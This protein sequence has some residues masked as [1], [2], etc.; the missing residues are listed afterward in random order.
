MKKLVTLFTFLA[1]S[2]TG[3]AQ[4][5]WR[6][7]VNYIIDVHLDDSTNS[8]DGFIKI[9]YNNQSPDTLH[10]IWFHL[11]PNAYKNDRTAYSEQSLQYRSTRFYFSGESE[12]GY[13]NQLDFRVDDIRADIED[14]PEHQDIIKLVLPQPLAPGSGVRISTPFHVK[15]PYNFSGEG[16]KE[17][18]FQLVQWYPKPA[19]YDQQGWHPMP[20][21]LR[22]GH[23]SESGNYDVTISVPENYVVAASGELLNETERE[24]LISRRDYY[25]E[26]IKKRV[27]IGKGKYKTIVQKYPES[28]KTIKRLRFRQQAVQ[29]FAWAADKRWS[30]LQDELTLPEQRKITLLAYVLP[31]AKERSKKMLQQVKETLIYY[32]SA[33]VP[34]PYTTVHVLRAQQNTAF[35]NMVWVGSPFIS[36]PSQTAVHKAVSYIWT[37]SVPAFNTW[38]HPWL[39]EGLSSLYSQKLDE[40]NKVR[41][42][43]ALF[44]GLQR[45]A[46][47]AVVTVKRDQPVNLA[48][49]RYTK[50][51]YWLSTNIKACSWLQLVEDSLGAVAFS[52]AIRQFYGLSGQQHLYPEDLKQQFRAQGL[53]DADHW[54]QQ[55]NHTGFLSSMPKRQLKFVR[56]D[57]MIAD[58]GYRNIGLAPALGYNYYDG[59]MLGGM[60]HNYSVPFGAFQFIAIPLYGFG[61]RQF[62]GIF[63]TSYSWYPEN[64]LYK[65]E[66]GMSGARFTGDYFDDAENSKLVRLP[67]AKLAPYIRAGFDNKGNPD[68]NRYLQLKYYHI[69]ED[70][71]HFHSNQ[72]LISN[73]P[74][75]EVLHTHRGLWQLKW[76][77]ENDRVLYPYRWDVQLDA[78]KDFAR[79]A[80]TGNYFF[81]YAK[82][83]GMELRAFAGKFFYI[84]DNSPAKRAATYSYHLNMTTP[85]GDEDY[86]YSNYFMGRNEFE[87]FFSRQ[88]MLRDGGFKVRTDLLSDKIGR[89]DNWI[90]ALNFTSSLHPTIP[91]KLFADVGTYSD[92]WKTGEDRE[93]PRILFDAGLQVSLFKDLLNIYVPL[94]YSKVYR[95]YFKS[96]PGN[97]FGQRISFSID[98]QKYRF[99]T[100][101]PILPL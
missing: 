46:L 32:D 50:L 67:Y 53:E 2:I 12:R 61:S 68:V 84:G 66:A 52:K 13:I 31:T 3:F 86:T 96:T 63:R 7:Q 8:L 88:V 1:F 27:R 21:L 77:T 49:D 44:A 29:D 4:Q 62:N 24:W 83:G 81:N 6:Q 75:Y 10:Y 64:L 34:M 98:I 16:Y 33:L 42:T 65:L 35:A 79:I 39:Q 94:L 72:H 59:F 48:A 25:W 43:N 45:N 80:L 54:F 47:P 89:S 11:W 71:L 5:Y 37:S 41:N 76:V 90:G 85:K 14:H 57:R 58:S 22:G 101:H 38:Q 93:D 95:N 26:P 36:S 15:I 28:S 78:G 51:N 100:I 17:D 74:E 56:A 87:G 99:K 97:N 40:K 91:V 60:V 82:G 18:V 9:D 73:R 20:Y 19:V 55:L 70:Q 30:V 23:Y 92:A 69:W